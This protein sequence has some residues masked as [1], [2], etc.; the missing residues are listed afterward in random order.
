MLVRQKGIKNQFEPRV[1]C[2]V[3]PLFFIKSK[4][5]T[6]IAQKTGI[7]HWFKIKNPTNTSQTRIKI[8]FVP[9]K[10]ETVQ[11]LMAK[12]IA[13][14][15]LLLEALLAFQTWTA[16]CKRDRKALVTWQFAVCHENMMLKVSIVWF[17]HGV[18]RYVVAWLSCFAKIFCAS[19]RNV[20]SVF[21][22]PDCTLE[23]QLSTQGN[24]I[25]T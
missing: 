20:S 5:I 11:F 12:N 3:P 25:Y 14:N 6:F 22:F 13:V 10:R 24:W 7:I 4:C 9:Y 23:K 1:H 16:N 21:R 8:K 18:D 19:H 2:L 17:P 15:H